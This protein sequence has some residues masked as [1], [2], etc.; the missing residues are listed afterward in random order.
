MSSGQT[1]SAWV[2][3]VP[4]IIVILGWI[5]VFR[6]AMLLKYRDELQSI[7]KN[8]QNVIDQIF[9]LSKD[10]Y[11]SNEEHIGF[12]SADIRSRFLLLSHYLIIE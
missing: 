6:Q 2:T 1:T 10:Y 5:I 4:S 8:A 3:L 11:E 7:I 12:V 9:A